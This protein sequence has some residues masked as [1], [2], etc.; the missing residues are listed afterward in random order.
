MQQY[1]TINVPAGIGDSVWLMMKLINSGEK[2]NFLLPGGIPRR[3]KQI[4][5]LIP[6]LTK[7][8][9]YDPDLYYP[10][11]EKN[12]IQ[13]RKQKWESITEPEFCLSANN[14]LEAGNHISEFFPD[15]ATTYALPWELGEFEPLVQKDI[16]EVVSNNNHFMPTFIGIYGSS[17]STQ[18]AWGFWEEK[19]WLELIKALF[20]LNPKF[21]FVMI[22]AQWDTDMASKLMKMMDI[23]Y[24]P[25]FNTIGKP[26]G[27][28][29]ELMKRLEFGFYFPSGLGI[30]SGIA[31]HASMMWYPKFLKPM[32]HK[33]IWPDENDFHELLM[34]QPKDVL[35][36][37]K[38]YTNLFEK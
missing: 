9:N 29:M 12:N 6:S 32:M 21:H 27:Y 4:F 1:R 35:A 20:K 14:W 36:Y 15:L 17:Y 28:V 18:R 30:L 2:F 13:L 33:F 25:Y 26:L 3:G 7:T 31:G 19:E 10:Q 22:G 5:D 34:N 16:E 8:A 24:I 23:W 37:C 38:K 11:I